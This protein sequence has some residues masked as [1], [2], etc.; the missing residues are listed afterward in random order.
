MSE[1]YLSAS[2][3]CPRAAAPCTTARLSMHCPRAAAG[4]SYIAVAARVPALGAA[5]TCESSNDSLRTTGSSLSLVGQEVGLGYHGGSCSTCSQSAIHS[6]RLVRSASHRV[7]PSGPNS[8]ALY[9]PDQTGGLNHLVLAT[10]EVR[11]APTSGAVSWSSLGRCRR[12][13]RCSSRRETQSREPGGRLAVFTAGMSGAGCERPD[14]GPLPRVWRRAKGRSPVGGAVPCFV[15]QEVP[16][17]RRE[18]VLDFMEENYVRNEPIRAGMAFWTDE[19]SVAELRAHWAR[20][21]P[22]Q[23]SLVALLDDGSARPRVVGANVLSIVRRGA[24]QDDHEYKGESIRKIFRLLDDLKSRVDP[25]QTYGVEE[26]VSA[27][28]LAV[29]KEYRGQGLGLELLSTRLELCRALGVRLTV[30]T[31][32]AIESQRL[33]AK[34]GFRTIAEVAYEDYKVDGE[35]VFPH[36]SSKSAKLMA[37]TVE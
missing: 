28:G 20:L 16:P 14:S 4:G 23:P 26:Y 31:F 24:P 8:E 34:L 19:Q 30:T 18:D 29:C 25:F 33:A 36:V 11:L 1:P 27:M 5:G 35:V 9:V 6:R 12:A 32:T 7:H 2:W 13:D 17:D 10:D 3:S 37:K 21:L 15:V 22:Q